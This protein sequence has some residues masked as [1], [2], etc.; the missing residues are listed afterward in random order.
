LQLKLADIAASANDKCL[1]QI[2]G[3]DKLA[4][5]DSVEFD[6]VVQENGLTDKLISLAL[7]GRTED[8]LQ[9]AEYLEKQPG[10]EHHAV[11]L[12]HKAC[13]SA[14]VNCYPRVFFC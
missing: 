11:I 8:M 13:H 7:L 2:A 6:A 12:Y 1:K 5:D 4:I 9:A 10:N 3:A 14:L